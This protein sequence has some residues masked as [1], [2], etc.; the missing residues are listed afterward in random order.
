MFQKRSNKIHCINSTHNTNNYEFPLATII[1][2]DEFNRGYPVAWLISNHADELTLRPF[3]EEI[4]G[5][6]S[7]SFKVN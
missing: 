5:R 4:K 7:D 1:V 3:L 6:C 2:P